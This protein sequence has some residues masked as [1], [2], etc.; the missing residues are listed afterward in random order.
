MKKLF[1]FVVLAVFAMSFTTPEDSTLPPPVY[2][3]FK[4]KWDP[5]SC[6]CGTI[7]YIIVSYTLYNDYDEC[8][9]ISDDV[10][11]YNT[12]LTEWFVSDY[13]ESGCLR[14][15]CPNCYT[16]TAYVYYYDGSGLCCNGNNSAFNGGTE[17]NNGEGEVL[18]ELE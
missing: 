14:T 17:L 11:L 13:D 1:V 7:S 10:T 12:S 6:S 9:V 5:G 16:L 18:V 4:I 2:Y 8:E 15:D 3:G